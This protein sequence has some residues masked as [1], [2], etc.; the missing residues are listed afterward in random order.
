MI[1]LLI[2]IGVFASALLACYAVATALYQ[3]T[4]KEPVRWGGMAG[5]R[6]LQVSYAKFTTVDYIEKTAWY[7][8]H[9]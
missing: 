6:N 7:V 4:Q 8:K 5:A 2:L 9:P 1:L 3:A